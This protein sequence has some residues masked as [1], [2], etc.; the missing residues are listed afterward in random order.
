MKNYD[1]SSPASFEDLFAI[2]EK[3][4]D[5]RSEIKF[6]AGGTD[7]VPKISLEREAVPKAGEK[8]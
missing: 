4:D 8:I 6:L 5:S 3:N 1:Y 7:L 2:I